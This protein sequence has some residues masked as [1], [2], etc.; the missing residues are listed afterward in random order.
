MNEQ[1][2]R[3]RVGVF[4]L[5]SFILLAVLIT[6]FGGMPSVFKRQVEYT[7]IFNGREVNVAGV[8]PGT[9]VRKSGV[10]IGEVKDVRLDNETGE[11]KIR[12][13]VNGADIIREN[14][15]PM[16]NRGLL[17]GDTSIEFTPQSQE[18]A[19]E[20]QEAKEE[21]T[22]DAGKQLIALLDKTSPKHL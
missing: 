16:L 15:Q 22:P 14:D 3:F 5:S 1:A 7:I 8:G 19:P 2:L 17:G 4:V 20:K 11:V 6:L 10:P 9:P 18:P 12:I 21:K 13:G